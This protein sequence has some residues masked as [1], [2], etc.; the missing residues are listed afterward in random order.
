MVDAVF[1]LAK[2]LDEIVPYLEPALFI[3]S[4][5]AEGQLDSGLEGFVKSADT[6]RRQDE[7]SRVVLKQAEEDYYGLVS[8][9]PKWAWWRVWVCFRDLGVFFLF[10]FFLG[11]NTT[12]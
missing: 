2:H 9:I 11:K 10:F 12:G 7:Y 4:G 3:Q 1:C 5:V 6:I 8:L